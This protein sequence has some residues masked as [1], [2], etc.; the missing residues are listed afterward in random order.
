MAKIASQ[1]TCCICINLRTGCLILT[2]YQMLMGAV[3]CILSV[4]AL[5]VISD[6]TT[7]N[8]DQYSREVLWTVSVVLLV[9]SM[10]EF[11]VGLIGVIGVAKSKPNVLLVYLIF[12]MLSIL[13]TVGAIIISLMNQDTRSTIQSVVMVLFQI[14]FFWSIF[15]YRKEILTAR[16]NPNAV[17][18]QRLDGVQKDPLV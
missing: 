11:A 3:A 1:Q 2:I 9:A 8:S 18:F 4:M 10:I 5:M 15:R 14:Y 7:N 17:Q 12:D 16:L 13:C 6:S